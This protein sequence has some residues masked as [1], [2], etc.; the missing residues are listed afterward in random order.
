MESKTK[1]WIFYTN[2]NSNCKNT[3]NIYSDYIVLYGDGLNTFNQCSK[4]KSLKIH[5]NIEIC[6]I[7]SVSHFRSVVMKWAGNRSILKTSEIKLKPSNPHH[8]IQIIAT[9]FY[10]VAGTLV[11][12][13]FCAREKKSSIDYLNTVEWSLHVYQFTSI[14]WLFSVHC[15]C[16]H[17]IFCCCCCC[18][19]PISSVRAYKDFVK[20]QQCC[21]KRITA[22]KKKST[23]QS[24][25]YKKEEEEKKKMERD[26]LALLFLFS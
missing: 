23:D 10:Y 5:W 6:S 14:V 20:S 18:F 12:R 17:H 26:L 21:E 19:A 22:S 15:A 3:Y 9:L 1:K 25:S 24:T 4:Y 16:F 13:F 11:S 8:K 7:F 2:Q